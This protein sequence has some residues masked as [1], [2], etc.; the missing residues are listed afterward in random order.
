M[1]TVTPKACVWSATIPNHALACSTTLLSVPFNAPVA[2][3]SAPQGEGGGGGHIGKS[4]WEAYIRDGSDS[5]SE[6]F[7]AVHADVVEGGHGG[8]VLFTGR[9][10][11]VPLPLIACLHASHLLVPEP[12]N[13]DSSLGKPWG[14][15]ARCNDM[16]HM[17]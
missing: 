1:T 10:H 16:L 11:A 12:S 3:A 4:C 8:G 13:S 5:E 14:L 17:S 15:H 7:L 2:H 9:L 6:H